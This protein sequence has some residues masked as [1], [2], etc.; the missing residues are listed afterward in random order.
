MNTPDSL[1]DPRF[2]AW[3]YSRR[4]LPN[5]E[6]VTPDD[7]DIEHVEFN[8][9]GPNPSDEVLAEAYRRAQGRKLARLYQEWQTDCI[10]AG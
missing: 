3:L 10:S 2:I 8:P 6:G 4:V 9:L 5:D 1:D 7:C